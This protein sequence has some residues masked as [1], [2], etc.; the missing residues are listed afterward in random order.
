MNYNNFIDNLLDDEVDDVMELFNEDEISTE[1]FNDKTKAIEYFRSFMDALFEKSIR[2]Y[3]NDIDRGT[4]KFI[5]QK[6]IEYLDVFLNGVFSVIT[7][8]TDEDLKLKKNLNILLNRVKSAI[9]FD[10]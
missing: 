8:E 6:N 2:H 4:D 7:E 5:A 1:E 10:R 3:N 9:Y